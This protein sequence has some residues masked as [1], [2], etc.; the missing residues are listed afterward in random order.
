MNMD[1]SQKIID[2]CKKVREEYKSAE[3]DFDFA[4][5]RIE[6]NNNIKIDLYGGS[7]TSSVTSRIS[8][9]KKA[10]EDLYYSCQGLVKRLDSYCR[11]L[12]NKDVSSLAI[13]Y[14]CKLL[15]D[16]NDSSDI[17]ANFSASLNNSLS[18]QFATV[19]L[20]PTPENKMIE[21]FWNQELKLRDDWRQASSE[22]DNV[23]F[24]AKRKKEEDRK[25]YI[26]RELGYD[27][28]E[29]SRKKS[30]LQQ[31][32]NE[33]IRIKYV[34]ETEANKLVSAEKIRYLNEAKKELEAA[35][36]KYQQTI[37]NASNQIRE[38]EKERDAA[39]FFAFS[40]K[41]EL[42]EK[43]K[44]QRQTINMSVNR[45]NTAQDTYKSKEDTVESYLETYKETALCHAARDYPLP[46]Q[47]AKLKPN[48]WII[49]NLL[50]IDKAYSAEDIVKLL[51]D[52][53][54]ASVTNIVPVLRKMKKH[55]LL[56]EVN[57][58]GRDY[59]YKV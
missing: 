26:K 5:S 53:Y 15:H 24:Q 36:K 23:L 30:A 42:K 37:L 51:G 47:P 29:E 7:V 58:M 54:D 45:L 4:Q 9:A 33:C 19:K 13:T 59:Y 1:N 14:V 52:D 50:K 22:Y 43:I 20:S 46:E 25:N 35:E 38:L 41:R 12:L 2:F 57:F 16:L 44:N 32:K 48:G 3:S 56:T 18:D 27:E 31:Y 49:Y 28:A 6:S 21:V 8:E 55:A 40:K 34:R 11:P 17:E 10:S 39:G